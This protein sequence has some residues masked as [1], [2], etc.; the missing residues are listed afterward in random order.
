M[1]Q[2]FADLVFLVRVYRCYEFIFIT[3]V[4]DNLLYLYIYEIT[5][6]V[7]VVCIVA[8][9]D[10]AFY[11]RLLRLQGLVLPVRVQP[12]VETDAVVH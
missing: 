6:L 11:P 4:F 10:H 2:T 8:R 3:C 1:L 5:S 7:Q 12:S 9:A